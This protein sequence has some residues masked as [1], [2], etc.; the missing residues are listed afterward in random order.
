MHLNISKL[1]FCCKMLKNNKIKKGE[2]GSKVTIQQ[3][4][5]CDRLSILPNTDD[6]T[7]KPAVKLREN[8]GGAILFYSSSTKYTHKV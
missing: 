1:L 8:P 3:R 7:P 2:I 6:Q 4:G 5:K